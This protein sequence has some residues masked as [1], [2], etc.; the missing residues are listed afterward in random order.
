MNSS[1][2]VLGI[3][4]GVAA[5]ALMGVLFA[6]DKGLKTRKKIVA[7][8]KSSKDTLKDKLDLLLQTVNPI[9]ENIIQTNGTL[10]S[11]GERKSDSG[12]KRF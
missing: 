4:G 6:P 2:I 7:K 5:G 1:K 12:K 10:I 8:A 11:E 3:I 9:Y